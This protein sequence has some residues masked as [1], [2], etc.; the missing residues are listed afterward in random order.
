M[1]EKWFLLIVFLI[2]CALLKTQFMV[3]QQ[4]TVAAKR[5]YIEKHK[6]YEK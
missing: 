3:F 1:G 4:N 5:V 6:I 2:S